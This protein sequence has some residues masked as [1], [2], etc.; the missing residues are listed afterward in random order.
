MVHPITA[1]TL[2]ATF[3][4]E[5]PPTIGLEEELMLLDGTT[6]DLSPRA[7]DVLGAGGG[8]AR[9]KLELPAAQLEIVSPPGA[10][11]GEAADALAAGRR[12]LAA[13][14]GRL[15]LRLAGA[16][17]HPFAAAEGVLNEGAR[18]DEI[19]AEYGSVAR[20]QLVFGLHVHVAV[21]GGDRPLR[22]HD[23][24]RG[25]LPLLAAL[26]ANAPFHAGRDTGLASVRPKISEALPRQ[27]VPP[28]LGSWDALA[29][30]LRWTGDPRQWWWELRLHPAYGTVELRVPDAQ[31]TVADAAAM[32]AVAHALTVWLTQ[33]AGAGD[34]PPPADT[35]RI[36]DNRWSACRHGLAGTMA[37]LETGQRRPTA[38][39]VAGLLTVLE[40][41]A[42]GL[43][44]AMELAH[45]R[46]ML[47]AGGPAA[48][49][50]AVAEEA[51]LEGLVAWLAGRFPAVPS[52]PAG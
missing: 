29:A 26:A 7:P 35:W 40:P 28:A 47:E 36:A 5:S 45:A 37:D 50:R 6:L 21:R 18:Y 11:V 2:R 10:T 25:Y 14:A 4:P 43:G 12:D 27:G 13:L 23:A 30:A 31:T 17:A 46:A 19:A 3:A 49:A 9:F 41:V 16:G 44:C 51:G 39:L 8:D 52:V 20:R 22:V 1:G 34:L 48:R 42:A 24:L 15:G 38:E 32:G 33:R